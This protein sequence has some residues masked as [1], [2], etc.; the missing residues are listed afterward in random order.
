MR[1]FNA[2]VR[3]IYILNY[4]TVILF[5]PYK[6]WFIYRERIITLT[7]QRFKRLQCARITI[8]GAQKPFTNESEN[9]I[10]DDNSR[11]RKRREPA[12]T[13]KRSDR[14]HFYVPL[15]L[16]DLVLRSVKW[17]LNKVLGPVDAFP[18][19]VFHD[20]TTRTIS[21]GGKLVQDERK[22]GNVRYIWE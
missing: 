2:T 10:T 21:L 14:P 13:L 22:N 1:Y 11:L 6:K 12:R 15:V 18:L 5:C 20:S 4:I 3:W 9:K 8:N 19:R 16:L 17:K 7:H